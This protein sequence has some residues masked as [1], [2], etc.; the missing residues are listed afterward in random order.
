[1]PAKQRCLERRDV[2]QVEGIAAL[3]E[4]MR[5]RKSLVMLGDARAAFYTNAGTTD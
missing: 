4:R 5:N 1:M 3:I 2:E